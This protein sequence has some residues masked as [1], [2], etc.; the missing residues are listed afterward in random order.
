MNGTRYRYLKWD[1]NKRINKYIRWLCVYRVDSLYFLFKSASS[2]HFNTVTSYSLCACGV[3][4]STS[5]HLLWIN[6]EWHKLK[7][8]CLSKTW[9]CAWSHQIP[10]S[11]RLQTVCTKIRP[12]A[13]PY[14]FIYYMFSPHTVDFFSFSDVFVCALFLNMLWS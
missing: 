14:I 6:T 5:F 1:L 13:M 10:D 7:I 9:K 11:I 8:N 4:H 3:S 12:T 2:C